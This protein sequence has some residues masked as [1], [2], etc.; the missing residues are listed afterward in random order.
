M[1]IPTEDLSRCTRCGATVLEADTAKM[2]KGQ[3]VAV[4]LCPTEDVLNEAVPSEQWLVSANPRSGGKK[5]YAGQPKTGLQRQAMLKSG[6]RFHAE[7]TTGECG[8]IK[9]GRA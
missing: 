3:T 8:K 5:Y 2:S 1:E 9:R 4:L 7:H 6:T